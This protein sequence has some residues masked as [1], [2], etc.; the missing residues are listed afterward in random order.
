MMTEIEERIRAATPNGWSVSA[1]NAATVENRVEGDHMAFLVVFETTLEVQGPAQ[2]GI[3]LRTLE[4][5]AMGRTVEDIIR[6]AESLPAVQAALA[7]PFPI[8]IEIRSDVS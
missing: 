6:V 3:N 2:F 7:Y 5:S 1:P 8:D 4:V